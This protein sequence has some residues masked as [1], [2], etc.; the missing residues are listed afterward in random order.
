MLESDSPHSNLYEPSDQEIANYYETLAEVFHKHKDRIEIPSVWHI[1]EN[2]T[3]QVIGETLDEW[4]IK[5]LMGYGSEP[6]YF[7]RVMEEYQVVFFQ[8]NVYGTKYTKEELNKILR[9]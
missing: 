2:T 1:D 5:D 8:N 6:Q 4:I 9:V 3:N 7:T